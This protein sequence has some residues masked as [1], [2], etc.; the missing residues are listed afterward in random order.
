MD[1][2]IEIISPKYGTF[3]VLYDEQDESIIT[4]HVWGVRCQNKK[5]YARTNDYK[6][7]KSNYIDLHR[8]IMGFPKGNIDHIDGNSLNNKRDNLRIATQSENVKNQCM[9]SSN[10]VG[11][12][13]VSFDKKKRKYSCHITV[14]YKHIFGGY[15]L[16]PIEAAKKYNELAIIHH[17]DFAFLNKI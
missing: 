3:I 11:Y 7:G 8:L 17:G 1:K 14:N 16:E 15:F 2:K 5:A 13:G 4:S 9:K 10:T 12:K 6:N